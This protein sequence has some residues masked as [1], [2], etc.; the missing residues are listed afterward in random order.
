ML[1]KILNWI[2]KINFRGIIKSSE[3]ELKLWYIT[4]DDKV[5]YSPIR[6]GSSCVLPDKPPEHVNCRCVLEGELVFKGMPNELGRYIN[7]S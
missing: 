2:F 5:T 1:S 3:P 7:G 4:K 6:I